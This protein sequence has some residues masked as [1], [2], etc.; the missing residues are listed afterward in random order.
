MRGL[1]LDIQPGYGEPA[2]YRTPVVGVAAATKFPEDR[3]REVLAE[4]ILK[5]PEGTLWVTRAPRRGGAGSADELVNFILE[6]QNTLVLDV[7]PWW[8]D[9]AADWRDYEMV[10]CCS[11]VVVFH[12]GRS[13]RTEWFVR[14]K[15]FAP[16]IFVVSA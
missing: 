9:K 11:K 6:G 7:N 5:S 16:N 3:I 1:A 10:W 4:G 12:A 2:P 15:Q 13:V 14:Q 8:A